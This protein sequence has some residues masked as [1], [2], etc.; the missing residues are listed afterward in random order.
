MLELIH[1][2]GTNI[3]IETR[4]PRPEPFPVY[5]PSTVLPENLRVLFEEFTSSINYDYWRFT[6]S[7]DPFVVMQPEVAVLRTD[8]ADVQGVA[9][10]GRSDV[11]LPGE[12]WAI[13]VQFNITSPGT[14]PPAG[15][16]GIFGCA[17]PT[18]AAAPFPFDAWIIVR[19]GPEPNFQITIFDGATTTDFDT[20]IPYSINR[21]H[22]FSIRREGASLFIKA[23]ELPEAVFPTPPLPVVPLRAITAQDNPA[24]TVFFFSF[25][26]AIQTA[27][28]SPSAVPTARIRRRSDG[29]WFNGTIIPP[30]DPFQVAVFDNDMVAVDPVELP[31]LFRLDVD[32]AAYLLTTPAE[33][34]VLMRGVNGDEEHLLRTVDAGGGGGPEAEVP[35]I[36]HAVGETIRLHV[37]LSA[38]GLSPTVRIRRKSDGKYFNGSIAIP[39]DPFQVAV[40]DNPMFELATAQLPGVYYFDFPQARDTQGLSSYLVRMANTTPAEKQDLVLLTGPFVSAAARPECVI[41]GTLLDPL[42]EPRRNVQVKA[43]VIPIATIAPATGV[44]L[45]EVIATTD[46]NGEFSLSLIQ[47]LRIRLEIPIIGYDKRVQVPAAASVDFTTL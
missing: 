25:L 20:G 47:G 38:T 22:N 17:H 35:E 26:A 13:A 36:R 46:E 14:P 37:S 10:I 8:G 11:I 9:L 28:G 15:N 43:T 44:T 29:R 33:Y 2:V 18:G 12:D 39:L 24:T 31:G 32:Q 16:A 41:F 6:S 42:Q 3:R 27:S 45:D 30:A 21:I 34:H 4:P 40:F 1:P 5:R 23:D 19:A 7:G